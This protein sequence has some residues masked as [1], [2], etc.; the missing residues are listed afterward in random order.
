MNPRIVCLM[1]T[2]CQALGKK[3]NKYLITLLIS[4]IIIFSE[5]NYLTGTRQTFY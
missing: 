4:M 2:M 3:L 1:L 5:I